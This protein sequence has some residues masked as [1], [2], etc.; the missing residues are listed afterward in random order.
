MKKFA[1][2]TRKI[3]ISVVGPKTKITIGM[4]TIGGITLKKSNTGL[5]DRYAKGLSP[6]STPAGIPSTTDIRSPVSAMNSVWP[7][8]TQISGRTNNAPKADIALTA[9]G[10]EPPESGPK[11]VPS[12]HS[13][14]KPSMETTPG[15][16]LRITLMVAPFTHRDRLPREDQ[17]SYFELLLQEAKC[18]HL[19]CNALN[20]SS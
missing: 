20:L 11:L 13:S 14:I 6:T 2:T 5:R 8:A 17:T 12:C 15:R 10:R 18:L 4:I 9:E 19:V 1:N 7:I 16:N 3:P